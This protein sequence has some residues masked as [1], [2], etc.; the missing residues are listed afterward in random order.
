MAATT[1]EREE[2]ENADP[3][4]RSGA[5][6]TNHHHFSLPKQIIYLDR[7]N[8]PDIWGDIKRTV[9]ENSYVAPGCVKDYHTVVLLPK[10]EAFD[11]TLYRK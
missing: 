9:D 6:S 10:Q 8:T 1:S 5:P 3:G 4:L 2:I 7:N 11:Q